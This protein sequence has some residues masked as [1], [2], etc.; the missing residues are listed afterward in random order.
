MEMEALT[1]EYSNVEAIARDLKAVGERNALPGRT[2][3]LVGRSRWKR[4][5]ERYESF[6]RNGALPATY[7]VVYG[8]AWKAVPKRIADGRQV[9][10]FQRKA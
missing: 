1:I 4:M 3:G 8:H 10:D 7:E 5:A 9:I 2:R 6:R